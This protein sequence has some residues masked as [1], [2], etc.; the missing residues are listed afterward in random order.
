MGIKIGGKIHKWIDT[1]KQTIELLETVC[2]FSDF[3]D[4]KDYNIFSDDIDISFNEK[5]LDAMGNSFFYIG[6]NKR[7]NIIEFL[8]KNNYLIDCIKNKS[9]I[10]IY[11]QPVIIFIYMVAKEDYSLID[12]IFTKIVNISGMNFYKQIEYL[13]NDLGLNPIYIG[14]R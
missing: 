2:S 1:K 8:N 12:E 4:N 3:C 10:F 5:I 14:M 13:F 7:K 9:D 6:F 11:R